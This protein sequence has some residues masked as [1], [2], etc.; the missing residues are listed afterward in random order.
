QFGYAIVANLP[1]DQAATVGDLLAMNVIATVVLASMVAGIALVVGHFM[2][3]RPL[4][5]LVMMARAVGDG[6]F[7]QRLRLERTDDIGRLADEMDAT[8]NKL[9]AAHR[10]AEAQMAALEQLRHS[11]RVSTLGRLASS[12]A[13]ELGNPLNVI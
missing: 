7:G 1:S 11:D 9:E 4:R 6:D 8:S 2:V 13:H 10:A 5:Q 12:V 3:L